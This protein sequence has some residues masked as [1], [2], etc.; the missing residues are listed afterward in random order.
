MSENNLIT[1][2]DLI[3]EN[4]LS[5]KENNLMVLLNHPPPEEWL[6]SHP[7]IPGHRYLTIGRVEYIL[8]RIFVKWWVEV[9][10]SKIMANS[11]VVTVRLFVI[12]PLSKEILHN[13]GIGAAPIQTKSGAGAMDWNQAQTSGVQMGA[14]MAKSYAFKDAAESFGKLFGKDVSR[15]QQID[16]TSLV[17]KSV[18]PLEERFE[19]LIIAATTTEDL[20]NLGMDE[21]FPTSLT[22][23][24]QF[25]YAELN[26]TK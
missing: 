12:D 5:V 20:D 1:M 23:K 14:P 7:I 15:K 13:D 22:Q 26:N 2:Q 24:I 11:V 16:Y 10:D 8:N 6:V 19:K 25:R 17:K 3:Q 21:D 4:E 18:D 9:L